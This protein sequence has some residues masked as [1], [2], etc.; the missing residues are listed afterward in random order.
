MQTGFTEMLAPCLDKYANVQLR[1]M[2]D[3]VLCRLLFMKISSSVVHCMDALQK[4][5][6]PGQ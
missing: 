1:R 5:K 3:S 4:D 6:L 2:G